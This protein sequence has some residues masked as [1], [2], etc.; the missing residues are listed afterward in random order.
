MV[1]TAVFRREILGDIAAIDML[2][3]K[4]KIIAVHD[5]FVLGGAE[6]GAVEGG[7]VIF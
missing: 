2:Q 5:D 1:E 6:R 7:K 4:D 3:E